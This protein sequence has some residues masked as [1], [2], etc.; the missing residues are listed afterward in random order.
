M[1]SGDQSA[2]NEVYFKYYEVLCQ[3]A[4]RRLPDKAS[5]EEIVQDVFI[6]LWKKASTLSEDTNVLAWLFT[7]LRNKVLHELRTESRRAKYNQAYEALMRHEVAVL[8][9]NSDINKIA[10][11]IDYAVSQLPDQPRTAFVL[12]RYEHLSYKEIAERMGISIKTVEKH[13]SKALHDLRE[14]LQDLH[15]VEPHLWIPVA[16]LLAGVS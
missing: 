6:T 5:I 12:S 4:F 13:M 14:M 3:K 10:N 16:L 8:Y 1:R 2:F 11:R 9:T 7:V 15:V